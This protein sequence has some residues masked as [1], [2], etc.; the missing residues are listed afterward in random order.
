MLEFSKKILLKVSFDRLLFEKELRKS[1][2]WIRKEE[3]LVLK[4]WCVATFGQQ[5]YDVIARTFENL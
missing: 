3:V 4:A 2:K 5:Y 1:I